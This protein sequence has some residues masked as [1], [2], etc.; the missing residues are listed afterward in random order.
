MSPR[1]RSRS[2]HPDK[3]SGSDLE[4]FIGQ[5]IRLRRMLMGLTQMELASLLGV[6]SQ[7]VHQFERGL[8]LNAS[9]LYALSRALKIPVEVLFPARQTISDKAAVSALQKPPANPLQVDLDLKHDGRGQ[10]QALAIAKAFRQLASDDRR[11]ILAWI[12]DLV[13]DPS[14]PTPKVSGQD[15]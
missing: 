7:H 10:P 13:V 4:A 11:K 8:H 12:N 14:T 2:A 3:L 5:Q 1:L 15:T 6:A 9:R